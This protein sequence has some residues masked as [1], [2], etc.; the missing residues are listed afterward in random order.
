MVLTPDGMKRLLNYLIM[1]TRGGYTRARIID[2]LKA[3]SQNAHELTGKLGYDYSTIRH[4]L[5]VLVDN[6]LLVVTGNRYGQLYSLTPE[7]K[8]NYASF[9]IIWKMASPTSEKKK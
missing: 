5:D 9:L 7:L 1:G 3:Q 8:N 6:N 4:H 2:A